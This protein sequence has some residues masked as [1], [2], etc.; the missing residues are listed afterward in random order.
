[1]DTD[2]QQKLDEQILIRVTK[3][4]KEDVKSIA[5]SLKLPPSTV[6]RAAYRRGLEIIRVTGIQKT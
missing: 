5:L 2:E 1:M 3:P 6:A 4:E